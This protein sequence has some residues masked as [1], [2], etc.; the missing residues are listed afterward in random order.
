MLES[1]GSVSAAVYDARGRLLRT[2]LRGKPHQAGAHTLHWDGLDRRGNPQPKG[3]YTVKFLRTPGFRVEFLFQL[4][5]RPDSAPYHMWIGNHSGPSALAVDPGGIYIG[6]HVSEA[7]PGVIKQSLDGSRRFWRQRVKPSTNG[8]IALA[9]NGR[10]K[11]YWLRYDGMV[12][13]LDAETGAG[14]EEFFGGG[15]KHFDWDIKHP[16]A[17]RPG[18]RDP[19]LKMDLAA[20][21]DTVAVSYQD[22]NVVR[23][24][25]PVS[26]KILAEVSVPR[27]RSVAVAGDGA[28]FVV[29]DSSLL[30]LVPERRP[31][32][33]VAGLT[34]ALH[35][36]CARSGEQVLVATGAPEHQV[37]RYTTR[38]KLLRTYGRRGGRLTG[39]C[40]PEDFF[41]I[42][43]LA[44][45][46]SGGFLV[47][48][49]GGAPRRVAHFGADGQLINEWPGPQRFRDL[50]MVDPRDPTSVWYSVGRW[51]VR[52]QVDYDAGTWR[53][54]ET[55]DFGD[56]GG[57]LVEFPARAS[58]WRVLYH[59]GE[60]YLVSGTPLPQVLHHADG[61]L[62]AIVAS[63]S[64]GKRDR[65]RRRRI[66]ELKDVS[67]DGFRS[68]SWTD[69]NGDGQVDGREIRLLD[70]RR[71]GWA[72]CGVAD[73]FSIVSVRTV[74]EN[75]ETTVG[76][77]RIPVDRWDGGIPIYGVSPEDHR[78][79]ATGPS[80]HE[81][82]RGDVYID[83]KGNQYATYSWGQ[84]HGEFFPSN[85]CGAHNRLTSWAPGG[86]LRWSVGRH[87]ARTN[88]RNFFTRKP[89]GWFHCPYDITGKV[90]DCLIIT[91]FMETPGM[92]WTDDGLYA[93]HF[94]E[95]RVDDGLPGTAYE[96]W[97]DSETNRLSLINR[98]C[99][100]R[101]A[102]LE[103]ENGE[104]I[105]F[106][107]GA[108]SAPVYRVHG[109]DGWS[110]Q[111][112]EIRLL[113]TPPHAARN[114][115]GLTAAY[116]TNANLETGPQVTR[117]E[118]PLWF[119]VDWRDGGDKIIDGIPGPLTSW[120]DGPPEVGRV[121]GFSARWTGLLEAPLT[122][123]FIF[124]TYARGGVRLWLDDRQVIFGWNETRTKRASPP[125]RL[126]AGR[127]YRIRLDYYTTAERP[128]L[129]LNWES[130]SLDRVRIPAEFLYAESP[131]EEFATRPSPR[132]AL[133][134]I[135]AETF[136]EAHPGAQWNGFVW[137]R[138]VRRWVDGWSEKG[139]Y[140]AYH[141]IDFGTGVSHVVAE[142]SGEKATLELR[143]DE[144]DGRTI[145]RLKNAGPDMAKVTAP[146]QEAADVRDLYLVNT[147]G[148]EL[149]L[150]W[151]RFER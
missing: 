83:R 128:A 86:E 111:E 45:D 139:A 70:F 130:E 112:K 7:P 132:D 8:P 150:R 109:W 93:G 62:T 18:R 42:A 98:D 2:L 101:G 69:R 104:V 80:G 31:E 122:E 1:A 66:A 11:L 114:G 107:A 96:W 14:G 51:F 73:D 43:D 119:G 99:A 100:H 59:D 39:P 32:T 95:G 82:S 144:P 21:H 136:D 52:A 105:W 55:H 103:R 44:A 108:N 88:T 50:E 140:L 65:D 118:G 76:L 3:S 22:Q 110:R 141:R 127:K 40:E 6:C 46:G 9:S 124:S 94:L 15:R 142:M 25:E 133:S 138:H 17:Q 47:A 89:T 126:E 63:G 30:R 58:S 81:E 77:F 125:V 35:L 116:Y 147:A 92:V 90:K 57:G 121:S 48:E 117:T 10:G 102:V 135:E 37:H 33:I 56:L 24:L 134:P 41:R 38:G 85:K 129:S 12:K 64:P 87:D 145:A 91:D 26:G 4:G 23:W 146:V 19:P 20:W 84:R 60:R 68:Y 28:I 29:T 16:D 120:A 49:P 27:P 34:N 61:K 79:I 54:R 148:G 75:D 5:V 78:R 151:I 149:R 115:G 106:A 113:Q 123:E 74:R 131:E 97:R 67:P 71:H 72:A 137:G 53:V 13:I 36:A 143:L